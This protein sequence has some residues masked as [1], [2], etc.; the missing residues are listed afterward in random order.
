MKDF[1]SFLQIKGQKIL[2]IIIIVLMEVLSFWDQNQYWSSQTKDFSMNSQTLRFKE[3]QPAVI[4]VLKDHRNLDHTL[5]DLHRNNFEESTISVLETKTN[6]IKRIPKD[7]YVLDSIMRGLAVG[8]VE[9]AILGLLIALEIIPVPEGSAF[10]IAGP[11]V[12]VAAGIAI[13]INVGGLTGAVLGVLTNRKVAKTYE[14]LVKDKG[15]IISI[16]AE[17]P[18]RQLT[19]KNILV[20]NGAVEILN[21]VM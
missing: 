14:S 8:F 11:I 9:G 7:R 18:R 4:G 17:D 2:G 21:P 10:V 1:T 20:L 19:A 13:G 5:D 6:D 16:H 15:V 12:S 3:L